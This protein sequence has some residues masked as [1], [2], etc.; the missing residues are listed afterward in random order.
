MSNIPSLELVEP[1]V[2]ARR[3]NLARLRALSAP[4][5]FDLDA[6]K[7]RLEKIRERSVRD[8]GWLI[9]D[10]TRAAKSRGI[11][12][13]VAKDERAAALYIRNAARGHKHLLINKSATVRALAPLLGKEGFTVV[14]T[15]DAEDRSGEAVSDLWR[16]WE[17][18]E[19]VPQTIWESF[20]AAPSASF[21]GKPLPVPNGRW[22]AV[23]GLSS[24]SA[25]D[26]RMY[27]VQHTHNLSKILYS[28]KKLFIVAGIEKLAPKTEDALFQARATA[29]F[30]LSAVLEDALKLGESEERGQPS[31]PPTTAGSSPAPSSH[32]DS[33]EVVFTPHI[34][35]DIHVILLDSGRRQ[36]L[37]SKSKKIMHCISC[38]GCRRGCMMGRLGSDSPRDA[39]LSGLMTSPA[40]TEKRGLYE[41]TMCESCK[42]AC[43]LEIPSNEYN[44]A[45]RKTLAMKGGLPEVF[46]KQS[47]GILGNGNPFGEAPSGRGQFYPE[48]RAAKGAPILLY[49][50]CVASFQRQKIVESAFKLLGAVGTEFSVLGQNETCCGY[51]L[52]VAGSRK[53]E[54]AARR[55]LDAIRA[56]GARTVVTTCAGCNKTLR[57]IYPDYFDVDF[58]VLHMVEYLARSVKE[59]KLW[60]PGE[61]KM[62]AIYHDPCDLGRAMGVYEPPRELLSSIPGL[63]MLEFHFNRQSSRCCGA[64]GGAKGYDNKLSEEHAFQRMKEA[65]GLG[66]DVVTSACPACLANLQI[67]IPRIKKETGRTL[68]LMDV[69]EIAARAWET[70]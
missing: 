31:T 44:L 30:G 70:K 25:K 33:K 46:H 43:P 7:K 61:L 28:A 16:S 35:E 64:G 12:V 68:R 49:L 48:A 67:V 65:V 20:D 56:S 38:K 55:N 34:P 2:G 53:F 58:E 37:R 50:G 32:K 27:F 26:G 54:E 9:E 42:N 19:P 69:S 11:R 41:C 15:Y 63:E 10:F 29:L 51:P 40:E 17:L 60:F 62:K 14:D 18:G 13:L 6:V 8:S 52:Y 36:L 47:D 59:G 5:D 21:A 24:A 23:V 22:A 4:V 39:A 1:S 3:T 66:A 45:L 57:K